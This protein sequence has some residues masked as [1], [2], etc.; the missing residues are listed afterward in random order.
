MGIGVGRSEG[1]GDFELAGFFV[2]DEYDAVGGGDEA[3]GLEECGAA[4]G[5]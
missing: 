4:D 5:W 2:G 3:L 1:G